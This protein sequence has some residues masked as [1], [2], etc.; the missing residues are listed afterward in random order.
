MI[1]G[2]E[3]ERDMFVQAKIRPNEVTKK[4]LKVVSCRLNTQYS[5]RTVGKHLCNQKGLY[6]KKQRFVQMK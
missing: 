6:N 1:R 2:R 4:E 5:M 3:V